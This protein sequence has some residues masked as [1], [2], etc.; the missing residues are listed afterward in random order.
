MM[1][2]RL[3]SIFSLLAFSLTETKSAGN[4]QTPPSDADIRQKVVGTWTVGMQSAG[5]IS[6]KGTVTIASDGG[7]VSSMTIVGHDSKQEVSY[8]GTWQVKGGALIETVTKSDSK[9]TP[10]GVV[11]RDRI[12]SV[13]EYQLVY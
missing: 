6:I 1:T 8:E 5:G 11:T 13:D 12:I 4:P 3:L 10:V 7:F 2:I 9:M